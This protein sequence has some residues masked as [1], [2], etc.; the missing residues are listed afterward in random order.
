MNKHPKAEFAIAGHSAGAQLA[1]KVVQVPDLAHRLS[2]ALLLA[3]VLDLKPLVDT[4]IGRG[5][6]L[7]PEA[8]EACSVDLDSLARYK[9]RL[10]LVSAGRDAPGL[11]EQAEAARERLQRDKQ[12]NL[13][14]QVRFPAPNTGQF[15]HWK[16]VFE[17]RVTEIVLF[18]VFELGVTQVVLYPL[19]TFDEDHFSLLNA[20]YEPGSA[21]S[22]WIQ[23]SMSQ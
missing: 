18:I 13:F 7:T 23:T 16:S 19:Q 3:P 5:I 22:Q 1:A 8:A 15:S 14:V 20:L 11:L 21:V 2:S 9:G 17:L 4:Y 12:G 10:L 6:S